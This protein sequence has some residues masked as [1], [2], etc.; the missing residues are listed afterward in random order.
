MRVARVLTPRGS[1][2]TFEI[3]SEEQRKRYERMCA[4]LGAKHGAEEE[5]GGG[6][7]GGGNVLVVCKVATPRGTHQTFEVANEERRGAYERMCRP[8]RLRGAHIAAVA[9]GA[10]T[11]REQKDTTLEKAEKWRC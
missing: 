4:P 1:H 8:L 10:V 9:A 3:V 7:G 2:A 5:D 6:G 11:P